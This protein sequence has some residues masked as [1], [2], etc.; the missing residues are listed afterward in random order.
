MG[1]IKVTKEPDGNP[2]RGFNSAPTSIEEPY[3]Y[4][5]HN[6]ARWEPK[7]KEL[8]VYEDYMGD[9]PE[10]LEMKKHARVW[11][12]KAREF[13]DNDCI[14]ITKMGWDC[15]PIKG[16]NKTTYSL[17]QNQYGHLVCNCQGY[18]TKIKNGQE[19][20]CSHCLAVKQFRYMKTHEKKTPDRIAVRN[21]PK[22][23]MED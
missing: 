21:K 22:D 23:V 19:G 15:K 18:Q 4:T 13:L 10:K 6:I 16:Y 3:H 8:K 12:A 5:S 17:F 11:L 2:I 9:D 1:R 7:S 20:F 14:K